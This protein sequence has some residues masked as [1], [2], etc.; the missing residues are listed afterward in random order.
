MLTSF[1]IVDAN[2]RAKPAVDALMPGVRTVTKPAR[3]TTAAD[4]KLK[5]A[6]SHRLTERH[7]EKG[8][9][10]RKND[11]IPPHVQ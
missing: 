2:V 1:V 11:C 8:D 9:L 5:R 3:P 4:N 7:H 6:E 10:Y